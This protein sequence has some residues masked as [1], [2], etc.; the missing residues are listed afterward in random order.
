MK[1]K[2]AGEVRI[3]KVTDSVFKYKRLWDNGDQVEYTLGIENDSYDIKPTFDSNISFQVRVE[4]T[5]II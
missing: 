2:P 4:V 3:E 1:L 5:P